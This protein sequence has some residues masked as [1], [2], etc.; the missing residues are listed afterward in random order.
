M[1]GVYVGVNY[2]AD[3]CAKILGSSAM[4]LQVPSLWRGSIS[5]DPH[6][7]KTVAPFRSMP[8]REN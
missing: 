3:D 7:E 1:C 4:V 2:K 6:V 5:E 8:M